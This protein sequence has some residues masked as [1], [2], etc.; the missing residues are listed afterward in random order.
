[1]METKTTTALT[2]PDYISDI[3]HEEGGIK[4][5]WLHDLVHEAIQADG[6]VPSEE[7]WSQMVASIMDEFEDLE[8]W[9]V[10]PK[11][12]EIL[13]KIFLP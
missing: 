8:L 1:M 5:A 13:S 3:L 12:G 7:E 11:A 6:K 10:Y 4:G 2:I 9:P